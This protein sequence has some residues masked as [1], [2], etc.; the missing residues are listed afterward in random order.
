M[1]G[2]FQHLSGLS[3]PH[4]PLNRKNRILDISSRIFPSSVSP[5]GPFSE[6]Q[7]SQFRR[8]LKTPFSSPTIS[9][10]KFPLLLLF[11]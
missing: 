8:R 11:H 2:A 7:S 3:S 1:H 10:V 9:Y 4:P 6:G 5:L